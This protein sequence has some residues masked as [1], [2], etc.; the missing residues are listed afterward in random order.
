MNTHS[1]SVQYM[2]VNY[3]TTK[4]KKPQMCAKHNAYFNALDKKLSLS[5]IIF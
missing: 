1:G 4:K 5:L 3:T 2:F